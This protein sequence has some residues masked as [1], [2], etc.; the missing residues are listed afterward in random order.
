MR[1]DVFQLDATVKIKGTL[2]DKSTGVRFNA[3]S[4]HKFVWSIGLFGLGVREYLVVKI[5]AISFLKYI[6]SR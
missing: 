3:E 4:L 2:D 1:F 5:K 6:A